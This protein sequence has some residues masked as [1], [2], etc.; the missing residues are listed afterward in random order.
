MLFTLKWTR[1]LDL[2]TRCYDVQKNPNLATYMYYVGDLVDDLVD[3]DPTTSDDGND[4]NELY[5]EWEVV[6]CCS[7]VLIWF[8]NGI[9]AQLD[10]DNRPIKMDIDCYRL[11]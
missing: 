8:K 1:R 4:D 7:Y 6:Y 3:L 10:N 11:S 2:D 5:E 9:D